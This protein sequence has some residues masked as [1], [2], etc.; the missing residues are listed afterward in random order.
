MQYDLSRRDVVAKLSRL[1][2]DADEQ[3]VGAARGAVQV[4]E[5]RRQDR[6]VHGAHVGARGV[7]EV[8]EQ[9]LAGV[10]AQVEVT[11]NAGSCRELAVPFTASATVVALAVVPRMSP[12]S[13]LVGV[14]AASPLK[15][16]A[17]FSESRNKVCLGLKAVT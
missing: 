11:F 8:H 14:M 4:L 3:H 9:Q 12:V 2:I 5:G 16:F 17:K 10:G 7:P 15:A 6:Q 13:T 1:G